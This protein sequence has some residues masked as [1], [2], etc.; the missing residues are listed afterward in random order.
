LKIAKKNYAFAWSPVRRLM[1]EAGAEIVSKDAVGMLLD[2]LEERSIKLTNM[3]LKFAKHA[4]RKKVTTSD[5]EL[6][7]DYY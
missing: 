6:A 2:F 3:A 7:I 5:M 4:N 1:S